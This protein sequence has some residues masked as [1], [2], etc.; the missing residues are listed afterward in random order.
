[1]QHLLEEVFTRFPHKRAIYNRKLLE[2]P[3]SSYNLPKST[4]FIK[5]KADSTRFERGVLKSNLNN[6]IK[7]ES[8]LIFDG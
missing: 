2:Y 5:V 1:M 4:L 8:I 3:Q 6:F 7:D